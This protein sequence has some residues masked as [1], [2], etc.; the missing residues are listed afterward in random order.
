MSSHVDS[1][2]V[3]LKAAQVQKATAERAARQ[4]KVAIMPGSIAQ[5]VGEKVKSAVGP[6][7]A[8]TADF[9]SANRVPLAGVAV[10]AVAYRYRRPLGRFGKAVVDAILPMLEAA[11]ATVGHQR[12]TA[13]RLLDNL[14]FDLKARTPSR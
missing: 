10:G 14:W 5:R 9:V 8:K 13:G 12:T 3:A 7:G 11:A 2:R 6:T 4:A 1:L